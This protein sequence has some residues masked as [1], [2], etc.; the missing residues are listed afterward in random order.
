MLLLAEKLG[1]ST[2]LTACFRRSLLWL[3]VYSVDPSHVD[4]ELVTSIVR[5]AQD[6]NAAEVFYRVITGGGSSINSLLAKLNGMPLLL[7]WG[8]RCSCSRPTLWACCEWAS[9]A[10]A[11]ISG[12]SPLKSL[13]SMYLAIMPTADL[14]HCRRQGPLDS[15]CLC[16]QSAKAVSPG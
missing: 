11:P 16:R 3:Q 8:E 12:S 4:E 13:R 7:C 6:P 1:G 2:M 9:Q 14:C 5:A 15:S 10:A